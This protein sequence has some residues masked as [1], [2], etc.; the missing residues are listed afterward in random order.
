MKKNIVKELFIGTV[1]IPKNK[2]EVIKWLEELYDM[3]Y[4]KIDT[5]HIYNNGINEKLIGQSLIYLDSK[6]KIFKLQNKLWTTDFDNP[7]KSF[8]KQL[9]LT[10]RKKMDYY[11]LHRPSMNFLKD[12]EAW[13][14]LIELKNEGLIK[15]IGVSN[16]DKDMIQYFVE[17]TGIKPEFNQIELSITNFRE[18]RLF[19]N[20][21]EKIK[22]QAW[23]IMGSETSELLKNETVKKIAKKYDVSPSTIIISYPYS[24]G[25][26]PIVTSIKKERNEMNRFVIQLEKKDLENLKKENKFMNKYEE[27]FPW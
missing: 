9:N 10:G 19:F 20:K 13:K 21:K 27:T 23:S 5:A 25:V 3:G 7:R 22:I 12:V 4:R 8:L 16:F 14:V 17:Y 2:E 6:N 11:M 24:L 15:H 1:N 26:T 18:D